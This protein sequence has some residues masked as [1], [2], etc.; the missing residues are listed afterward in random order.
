[1]LFVY[2]CGCRL[3]EFAKS[4]R[5]STGSDT[6]YLLFKPGAKF[7]NRLLYIFVGFFFF[8]WKSRGNISSHSWTDRKKEGKYEF[9]VLYLVQ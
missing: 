6:K 1:M 7:S 8:V 2:V 3:F 5:E 9:V 4:S